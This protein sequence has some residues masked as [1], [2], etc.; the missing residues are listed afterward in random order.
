V[1]SVRWLLSAMV[2]QTLFSTYVHHKLAKKFQ[3]YEVGHF[4]CQFYEVGHFF[5]QFYEV[6]NFF[7][8]FY[9]VDNFFCQF[10]EVGNF[11]CQFYEVGKLFCQFLIIDW[12][13]RAIGFARYSDQRWWWVVK[14]CV[15]VFL[16]VEIMEEKEK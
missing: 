10:Y 4:F 8:Q 7:C 9:E 1:A 5:C 2:S 6:G 16:Q 14:V 13:T 11:F 12:L 15:C 3:F